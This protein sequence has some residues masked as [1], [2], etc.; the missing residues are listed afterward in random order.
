M[1]AI[2]LSLL[3]S[4]TFTKPP[5]HSICGPKVYEGIKQCLQLTNQL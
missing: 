1:I 5:K 3:I 2:I 4:L